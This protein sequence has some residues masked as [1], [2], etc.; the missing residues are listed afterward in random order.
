[1]AL[2]IYVG[3]V[4]DLSVA[5]LRQIGAAA[6][7]LPN[8]PASLIELLREVA[9]DSRDVSEAEF[10]GA[11]VATSRRGLSFAEAD[12]RQSAPQSQAPHE[13]INTIEGPLLNSS[14]DENG[15]LVVVGNGRRIAVASPGTVG[16]AAARVLLESANGCELRLNDFAKNIDLVV[17][18]FTAQIESSAA[19]SLPHGKRPFRRRPGGTTTYSA[20]L[21]PVLLDRV[22]ALLR[23]LRLGASDWPGSWV[24]FNKKRDTVIV[25]YR[26]PARTSSGSA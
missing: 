12:F 9:S 11:I 21:I 4:V 17:A 19:V 23:K 6:C 14:T 25:Q 22:G 7:L 2:V 26:K 15:D 18:E 5:F 20:L 3:R 24:H 1:L 16:W 8:I 13:K 10:E